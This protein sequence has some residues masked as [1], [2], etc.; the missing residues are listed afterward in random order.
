M[1]ACCF[2][3]RRGWL[4]PRIG[5]P[6]GGVEL[7]S[8]YVSRKLSTLREKLGNG[9]LKK[10]FIIVYSFVSS[11]FVCAE[12]L[13]VS[14]ERMHGEAAVC[15]GLQSWKSIAFQTN[16]ADPFCFFFPRCLFCRC[17]RSW[18]KRMTAMPRT[19]QSGGWSARR[20]ASWTFGLLLGRDRCRSQL[21]F[22]SHPTVWASSQEPKSAWC[23]LFPTVA[24]RQRLG[25]LMTK[26]HAWFSNH[27][28][29]RM[30]HV[31]LAP[32]T[33][34]SSHTRADTFPL[35]EVILNSDCIF[36]RLTDVFS[37]PHLSY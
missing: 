4:S 2:A 13:L 37:S 9:R 12:Q 1:C 3:L 27:L 31:Q 21:H 35:N 20:I 36:G 17:R 7:G 34:S 29:R 32:P 26:D 10:G 30:H 16:G 19:D 23:F 28:F 24:H 14:D 8:M 11:S 25:V 15:L 5:G 33:S 22:L 6:G 18:E